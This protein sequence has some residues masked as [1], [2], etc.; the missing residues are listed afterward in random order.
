MTTAV[1]VT[2]ERGIAP[3]DHSP[4]KP[5]AFLSV[6]LS[7]PELVLGSLPLNDVPIVLDD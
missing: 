7:F 2:R 3:G 1:R 5:A 6:E 4:R